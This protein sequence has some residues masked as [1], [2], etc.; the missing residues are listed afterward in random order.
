MTSPFPEVSYNTSVEEISS[1]I[2]KENQA[3]VMKDL[4]G[5]YHIITKY[6]LIGALS[7]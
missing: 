4:A 1:M 5:V 2:S 7:Q 6:D 3:V